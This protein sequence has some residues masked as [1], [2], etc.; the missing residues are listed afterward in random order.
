MNSRDWALAAGGAALATV[1]TVTIYEGKAYLA[2]ADSSVGTE[3]LQ[4][5]QPAGAGQV[6]QRQAGSGELPLA[7]LSAVPNSSATAREP[8]S[9]TA[10][11]AVTEKHTGF[12]L[13]QEG[14][15]EQVQREKQQL[16]SQV[17]ALKSET[18]E[19]AEAESTRERD[20]FDLDR[21]DWKKLAAEGRIKYKVPCLL[22]PGSPWTTP[23]T[24]LDKLGLSPEDGEVVTEAHRRSN[25]RIW[26]TVRPLCEKA[27]GDLGIVDL[28]GGM[29]C[30]RLIQQMATTSDPMAA[31]DAQR[32]VAEVHAGMRPPPE[33]GQQQNPVFETF[34]ALTNEAKLYEAN[35]AETFGPEEA[36]RIAQS[37]GCSATLR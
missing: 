6:S 25:G 9:N 26:A 23:P 12:P 15:L 10:G 3:S 19:R 37:P 11:V 2:R 27:I 24:F 8:R 32:Q 14:R 22:P 16:E 33:P 1:A 17:L 31:M 36:K 18:V 35:L 30:L 7:G 5:L 13:G 29:G 4:A 34:M 20:E 28:L 21:D